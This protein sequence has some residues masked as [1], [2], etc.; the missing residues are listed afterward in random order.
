MD[1]SAR[2]RR[3]RLIAIV[4]AAAVTLSLMIALSALATG[5]GLAAGPHTPALTSA[6]W[7]SG[8]CYLF[9]T[10]NLLSGGLR[11]GLTHVVAQAA[12]QAP[13]T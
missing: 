13:A 12:Q 2:G 6:H 11:A 8:S 1:H 3:R 10:R 7:R 4:I 9:V 5:A